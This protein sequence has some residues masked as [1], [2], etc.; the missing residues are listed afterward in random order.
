MHVKEAQRTLGSR[1]TWIC[2]SMENDLKHALGGAPNSEFIIDPEGKVA[3]K[4][5]WS[6]PDELRSDLEQLV[7]QVENPTTVADLDMKTAAPPKVAESGVVPRLSLAGRA[8]PLEIVPDSN[9]TQ[10]FY[11]KLR[12]EADSELLQSGKGQLYVGFHM[13][14]LYHVHWNNLAAPLEYEIKVGEGTTIS[15]INGKSAKIDVDSDIDPREFL[16]DV[17]SDGE[18]KSMEL[19]VKYFACN[20]EEGWCKPITQTYVV[21]FLTDLD[22]GSARR[23]GSGRGGSGR[24]GSGRGRRTAGP[25]GRGGPAGGGRPGQGPPNSAQRISGAIQNVDAEKRVLTIRTSGGEAVEYYVPEDAQL[26]IGN[27]RGTFDK[28]ERRAQVM[29]SLDAEKKDEDGRPYLSRLRSR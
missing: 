25:G 1:V 23:G 11:A 10:P 8:S 13:D 5:Q 16:L 14:P 15:P 22:G 18:A 24:G 9:A 29:F 2:D 20:D 26:M 17:V 28:L 3:V 12:V 21:R 4:R 6:R 7:G 27:E 19:T